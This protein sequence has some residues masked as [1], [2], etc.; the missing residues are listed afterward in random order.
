[1]EIT[2]YIS[3]KKNPKEGLL[4]T[5]LTGKNVLVTGGTRGIGEAI[6]KKLVSQGAHVFVTGTKPAGVA[7]EGCQYLAIDFSDEKATDQF[8]QDIKQ[9]NFDILINNAGINKIGPFDQIASEDFEKIQTVNLKAPFK[10]CQAVIPHMKKQ[11][12]GRI[13]NISSIFGVISKEER[14]PYSA[15]KFALD[16]M[17]VAL[18]AEVTQYGILAN[19][20]CPG[21]IET[22]LTKQ[23][24]GEQGIQELS[25]RVPA[26]RLGQPNEVAALVAFVAGPE[27]TFISGQ[28]LIIDG[29]FTRV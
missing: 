2:Y 29:G 23:V 16:G 7:P 3:A 27:N 8:C 4:E 19:C 17:T 9:Y 10:L 25:Q 24:L 28:N 22:D 20:V 13:V 21:F 11:G 6:A 5:P 26:K 14:A 15:S 1:M 12:W 18:A